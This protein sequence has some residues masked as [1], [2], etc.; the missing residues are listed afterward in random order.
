MRQ[1]VDNGETISCRYR[2]GPEHNL[3]GKKGGKLHLIAERITCSVLA[4]IRA[5]GS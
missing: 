4:K 5:Q 1:V 2:M 3:T